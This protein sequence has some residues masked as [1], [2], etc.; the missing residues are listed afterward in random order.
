[1]QTRV[2]SR[3]FSTGCRCRTRLLDYHERE[4]RPCLQRKTT[5]T[6]RPIQAGRLT[7]TKR[8]K[9][10]SERVHLFT[11]S[12]SRFFNAPFSRRTSVETRIV[13]TM[14]P[15]QR[16]RMLAELNHW[17]Y[18][19]LCAF[20]NRFVESVLL[21]RIVEKSFAFHGDIAQDTYLGNA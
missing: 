9:I 10:Y 8:A 11:N 12:K 2:S 3:E 5:I 7:G 1:M 4:N 14:Q 13:R 19:L 20:S 18:S 6:R 16:T 21:E 17:P 15:S